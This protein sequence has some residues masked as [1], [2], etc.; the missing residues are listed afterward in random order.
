MDDDPTLWKNIQNGDTCALKVSPDRYYY[1]RYLYAKK[2]DHI[3][4]I[5]T[6]SLNIIV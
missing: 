3:P 1:Q 6:I 5:I 2:P 4:G